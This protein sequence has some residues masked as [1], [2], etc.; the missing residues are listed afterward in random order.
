MV[1]PDAIVVALGRWLRLLRSS[2]FS[3]ASEIIRVS[4]A[5]SDLTLTQY[6]S[7]LELAKH[8]QL[9]VSGPEGL[10][11]AKDIRTSSESQVGQKVFRV[12]LEQ[13]SP[14]W[15]ADADSLV[16]TPTELPHDALALAMQ[17][18]INEME[19]FAVVK[20]LHGK[21]D[22]E[23]RSRVGVAGEK[24]LVAFLEE[25]WPGSTDHIALTD[26]GFGYD[27]L[28]RHNSSEWHLEVKSTLRRGR[29]MVHLSRQ[30]HEVGKLDPAWRLVVV[31]LDNDLRLRVIAT[32]RHPDLLSRAPVDTCHEV[33]WRTASHQLTSQDL[34]PGIPFALDQQYGR[35]CLPNA[36]LVTSDNIFASHEFSWMPHL[37]P[38]G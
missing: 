33:R 30:E 17:L 5:F 4:A 20:Q 8:L 12:L 6:A 7:A 27:V 26:D 11:L 36:P 3:K 37:Q 24:A 1:L 23:Q 13:S 10:K 2:S 38:T 32:A 16:P 22:L 15:L 29:L 21:I 19:A 14:L 28:F 31:G 9:V 25:R 34:E 35:D 18:G